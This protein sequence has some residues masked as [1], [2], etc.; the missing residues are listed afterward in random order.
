MVGWV[1][2]VS[3]PALDAVQCCSAMGNF[4]PRHLMWDPPLVV[5]GPG[6]STIIQTG[7]PTVPET[8]ASTFK[9]HGGQMSSAWPPS[10][11]QS[12]WM[13]YQNTTPLGER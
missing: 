1:E 6:T 2:W 10:A 13:K 11:A 9:A 5:K 7:M 3:D 4:F 12:D 8:K